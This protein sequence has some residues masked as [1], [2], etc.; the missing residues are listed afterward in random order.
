MLFALPIRA[1]PCR[2]E[3]QPR[4]SDREGMAVARVLA[5]VLHN[6]FPRPYSCCVLWH[7]AERDGVTVN[8]S[9]D[10][11]KARQRHARRHLAPFA[12]MTT[13]RV[14]IIRGLKSQRIDR[15]GYGCR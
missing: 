8:S 4:L 2:R 11:S 6:N 10:L 7:S 13:N 5:E 12:S 1:G 9:S 14:K 15:I 3:R